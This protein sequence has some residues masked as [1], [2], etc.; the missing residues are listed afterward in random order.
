[1]KFEFSIAEEEFLEFYRYTIKSAKSRSN[2]NA[3]PNFVILLFSSIVVGIVFSAV[4]NHFNLSFQVFSRSVIVSVVVIVFIFLVFLFL[5]LKK[6]QRNTMP[7]KDGVIMGNQSL[8][9][10][11][12][13]IS[14]DKVGYSSFAKW[15]KVVS[16]EES[17]GNFYIFVDT[18]AAYIVPKH[19]FGSKGEQEEFC[20]FIKGHM[21]LANKR[22]QSDQQTAARSVDR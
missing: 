21:E 2:E 6:M 17:A 7:R 19:V 12:Q 3:K 10:T 22:M 18:I 16:L 1:M 14:L 13:G 5:S 20:I 4:L 8:E 9:L 11:G 15:E